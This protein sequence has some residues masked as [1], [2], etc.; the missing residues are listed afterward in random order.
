MKLRSLFIF[1]IF[2]LII[3]GAVFWG[4]STL[5]SKIFVSIQ[6]SV[7]FSPL[8]NNIQI[9]NTEECSDTDNGI[10]FNKEGKSSYYLNLLFLKWRVNAN[11]KCNGNEL[12]EYYCGEQEY[13]GK[14]VIMC[15]KGCING[16]CIN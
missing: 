15:E 4:V 5:I 2:V 12:T 13:L 6:E 10:F 3:I 11:D 1:F 16:A 14:G 7:Q 8:E 9:E